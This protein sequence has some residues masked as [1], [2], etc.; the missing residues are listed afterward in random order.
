M[1]K[2]SHATLGD[3]AD[4][5]NGSA[6]TPADWDCSGRKIIRIQ[7]LTDE[8]KPYNLTARQ[9]DAKYIVN[10]GDLLVSW[11][12]TLGVFEW[13]EE[14]SAVLNQHIFRVLPDE[15]KIAK[16]FLKHAL[17]RSV[18]TMERHTHGAT[19]KHINRAEFLNT[20]IYLPP[21]PEQRRIAAILDKVNTIRRKRQETIRLT[22]ESICSAFFKLVGPHAKG[23]DT[24]PFV[25]ME[26]LAEAHKGA[27]RTGPFGSDLLHSEFVDEGIAVLGIDN[28][29]QNRFAW[30]ERR[31]VTPE[32]YEDLK[33]YRVFSGDVI[34]TI[35]GTT[36]RSAVV[37][38]EIPLAITTKHLASITLNKKLAHPEFIA[39]SIHQHPEVLQQIKTANRGAIMD[40]LNLGLIKNL[41]LRLPPLELQLQFAATLQKIRTFQSHLVLASKTEDD[42]FNSL[43]QRAFRGELTTHG[44]SS[45]AVISLPEPI[46]AERTNAHKVLPLK[47]VK[48]ER[49]ESAT[50]ESKRHAG[51]DM[52]N[53]A[54]L[55]TYIVHKC[56]NPV[57]P[58]G[59]VKLAK[60]FYLVQRKADLA[61]TE[62]FT[63]RAAGPLDDAIHKFLPFAQ[64]KNWIKLLPQVGM[65]KPVGPGSACDEAIIQTVKYLGE[66][67]SVVDEIL[68]SLKSMKGHD[69]ECWATVDAV[70]EELSASGKSLTVRNILQALEASPE[71]RPKLDKPAFSELGITSA[72]LGLRKL[73]FL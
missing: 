51:H 46:H 15:R 28:A 8:S 16:P 40:G 21:L 22:E 23:Y 32:K 70:A 44:E 19:M 7:N 38:D 63:R 29:V 25:T 17:E 43:I 58:M 31:F 61:L 71:W 5:V 4:F 36:G 34:I 30:G 72:L 50:V 13:A 41:K 66:N 18:L 57:E 69:L 11:S 59:R 6:F 55:A 73:G 26:C 54:A 39:I 52:Y 35:M 47:R 56:H 67:R 60:L 62:T 20:P 68:D 48:K 53:K 2:V 45:E 65:K 49:E 27:M 64:K 9:V 37:P 42:L 10:S 12:A 33:R 3:V 1:S 14:E 24:W